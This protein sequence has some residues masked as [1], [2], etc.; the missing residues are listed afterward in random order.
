MGGCWSTPARGFP[1]ECCEL[2]NRSM[3]S[4]YTG[5]DAVVVPSESFLKLEF[6]RYEKLRM[7]SFSSV[8]VGNYNLCLVNILTDLGNWLVGLDQI[9]DARVDQKRQRQCMWQVL[10]AQC[11]CRWDW[12]GKTKDF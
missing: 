3:L 12:K 7:K 6:N 10:V 9:Q 4:S 8:E 5:D 11:C 2:L 1:G